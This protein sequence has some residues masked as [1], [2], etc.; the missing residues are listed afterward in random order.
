MKPLD[1]A[2]YWVEYIVRHNGAKNLRV[3]YLNLTWYEYL[4]VDVIATILAVIFVSLYIVKKIICGLLGLCI[5]KGD[6]KAEKLKKQ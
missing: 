5:G 2:I 4:L 1:D 3:N 6:K